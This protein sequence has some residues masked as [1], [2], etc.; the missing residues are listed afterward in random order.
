MF[1]LLRLIIVLGSFGAVAW[2]ALTV[3]LG[4]RTLLEHVQAIWKSPASRDLVRGTEKKVGDLVDRASNKV[5]HDVAKNVPGRVNS[6]GDFPGE[7]PA[8]APMDEVPSKDRESLRGLIGKGLG[9][10]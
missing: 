9:K 3:R 2:F 6:R 10:E 1:R 8:K 5:V 4:D 7:E